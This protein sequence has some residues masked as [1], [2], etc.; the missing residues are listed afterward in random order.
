MPQ[1]IAKAPLT[2]FTL[3][4][5]KGVPLGSDAALMTYTAEV[6]GLRAAR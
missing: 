2:A 5:V 4:Q 6:E 3:V 1:E